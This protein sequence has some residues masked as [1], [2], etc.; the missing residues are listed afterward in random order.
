MYY[1]IIYRTFTSG[2]GYAK[3]YTIIAVAVAVYTIHEYI[4]EQPKEKKKSKAKKGEQF[5]VSW[6]TVC[7]RLTSSVAVVLHEHSTYLLVGMKNF[8]RKKGTES[9][10]WATMH[11]YEIQHEKSK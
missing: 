2:Y 9:K 4:L 10:K 7:L 5:S 1:I 3:Q 6:N 11:G 8:I